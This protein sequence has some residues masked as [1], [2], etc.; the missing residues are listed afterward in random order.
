MEFINIALCLLLSFLG[1][2][3]LALN[4]ALQRWGRILAG[5]K[6]IE[7]DIEDEIAAGKS[8]LE[9]R[10]YCLGQSVHKTGV[11]DAITPAFQVHTFKL[12]WFGILALSIFGGFFFTW[13]IGVATFLG[14]HIA[15]FVASKMLPRDKSEVY[16]RFIRNGLIR[17]EQ[18][19]KSQNDLMRAEACRHFIDKLEES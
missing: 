6:T 17:R 9:A 8:R 11:M 15:S 16:L 2:V 7:E 18:S 10:G 13:Y 4:R 12:H 19:Y 3:R 5:L 14:V 1:G